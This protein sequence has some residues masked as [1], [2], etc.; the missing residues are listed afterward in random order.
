MPPWWPPSLRGVLS[1]IEHQG[2]GE[3]RTPDLPA[4]LE[5]YAANM[6]VDAALALRHG[7]F[8][9]NL[10]RHGTTLLSDE[11]VQLAWRLQD[12]GHSVRYDSRIVVH[13]Q[14]QATRFRPAWLLSRLYWQGFSTVLTR[15]SLGYPVWRE[16]P[17]RLAVAL[18][19]APL[20]AIPKASTSLLEARWRLA[21]AAGFLRAALRGGRA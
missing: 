8:G 19:Y 6:V 7:G 11:E 3:Y 21:Y 10:G 18:L 12:A 17:R 4:K 13:H 15:R 20:A 9:G 14:I 5:P 1:I 2:Q 16:L